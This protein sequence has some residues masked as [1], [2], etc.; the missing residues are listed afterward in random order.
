MASQVNTRGQITIDRAAREALE[1]LEVQPGMIAVQVVVDD[2]LEVYFITA[3]HQ[4]SV[5]GILPPQEPVAAEDWD[6]VEGHA[7][8]SI[9][10]EA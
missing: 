5:F 4:R 3:R 9:A 2:H 8:R 10:A 7:T 6:T 1:A